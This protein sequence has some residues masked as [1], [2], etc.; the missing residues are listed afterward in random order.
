[1]AVRNDEVVESENIVAQLFAMTKWT[2]QSGQSNT[3]SA[4]FWNATSC[5]SRG[6]DRQTCRGILCRSPD[7]GRETESPLLGNMMPD[8]GAMR[9]WFTIRPQKS[10]RH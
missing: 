3:G 9:L 2:G 5:K 6:H 8:C 7:N 4:R 10:K 1:M